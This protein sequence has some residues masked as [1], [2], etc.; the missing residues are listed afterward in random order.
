MSYYTID[1][2][3]GEWV[4]LGVAC[5]NGGDARMSEFCNSV[6]GNTSREFL[7]AFAYDVADCV[8]RRGR[9]E[10][11]VV[12][13]ERSGLR[14]HPHNLEEMDGRVGRTSIRLREIDRGF[15]LTFRG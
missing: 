10:R 5:A 4:F 15:E 7:N 6:I 12:G 14:L 1:E 9:V 8:R 3:D 13:S 2:L 11:L